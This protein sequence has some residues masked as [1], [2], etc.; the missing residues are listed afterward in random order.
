MRFTQQEMVFFNSITKGNKVL[1]IPLYF[2]SEENEEEIDKTIQ[3]L[4][5]KGVLKSETEL[6]ENGFLPAYTLECY[7]NASDHI[8]LNYLH[9]AILEGDD[10]AV[11][12]PLRDREYEMFRIP[13]AALLCQVLEEYPLLKGAGTGICEGEEL[14]DVDLF[15]KQLRNCEET[16]MVGQYRNSSVEREQVYFWQG[17][18]LYRYMFGSRIKSQMDAVSVRRELLN[19]LK[20]KTEE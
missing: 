1:G 7:K 10:A 12:I 16:I 4:I 3:G 14:L 18:E 8:I 17:K 13:R 2:H 6:S 11:I 9:I 5:K 19:L 20:I 15:L